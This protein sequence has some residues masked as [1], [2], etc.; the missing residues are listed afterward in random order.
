MN[1]TAIYE[2]TPRGSAAA[3]IDPL[4]YGKRAA[5]AEGG[6]ELAFLRLRYKLQGQ[7]DSKLVGQPIAAQAEAQPSERL[8]YAA[9]VAAFADARRGG[10][11]LDG[12]CSATH[13]SRGSPTARA[14]TM[15]ATIAPASCNW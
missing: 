10:K 4:R 1:V 5:S 6:S 9:A 11:Y 13:R 14:A 15:P 2:I 12:Y 7:S 3:R 8:R